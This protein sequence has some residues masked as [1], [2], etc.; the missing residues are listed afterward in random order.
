MKKA[1][2][3]LILFISAS[4]FLPSNAH[5]VQFSLFVE[6]NVTRNDAVIGKIRGDIATQFSIFEAYFGAN[7]LSFQINV[8]PTYKSIGQVFVNHGNSSAINIVLPGNFYKATEKTRTIYSD[9]LFKLY[10]SSSDGIRKSIAQFLSH[11][12][13]GIDTTEFATVSRFSF[14]DKP[15]PISIDAVSDN[16]SLTDR[17]SAKF[18]KIALTEGNASLGFFL[19]KALK[20]GL[21]FA[22]QEKY[23]QNFRAFVRSTPLL[24]VPKSFDK[25][26]FV[27]IYNTESTLWSSLPQ[28]PI[29]LDTAWRDD[30]QTKLELAKILI[31][32]NSKEETSSLV[33]EVENAIKAESAE[34]F[35]WW[36]I[37]GF[38]FL[39]VA[40]CFG[41]TL[42][43]SASYGTIRKPSS[44]PQ[45]V[46]QTIDPVKQ[47]AKTYL[48]DDSA[49]KSSSPPK[50]R[51]RGR[52]ATRVDNEGKSSKN[53]KGRS[54]K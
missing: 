42:R 43:L 40:F 23:G 22:I 39:V 48:V 37:A 19:D 1:I 49:Q 51:F 8:Y 16:F 25:D 46:A 54:K 34:S 26:L 27:K 5:C 53:T 52:P 47:T 21:N 50:P 31:L 33:V 41:L 38:L 9:L 10:P 35:S 3:F 4:F 15:L 28:H 24:Q 17:L 2:S 12:Y 29:P 45:K 20:N 36:F 44:V 32:K 6:P 13:Y 30:S 7:D 11:E 14:H 18:K